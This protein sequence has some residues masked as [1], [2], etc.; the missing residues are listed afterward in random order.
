MG[1]PQPSA[2]TACLHNVCALHNDKAACGETGQQSV[3]PDTRFCLKILKSFNFQDG[4][5]GT[6]LAP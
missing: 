6:H 5:H 1:P 2:A 4:G 3:L